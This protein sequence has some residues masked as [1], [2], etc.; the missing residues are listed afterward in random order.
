MKRKEIWYSVRN[1]GDGSAYPVFM[2][3]EK[4]TEIDQRY[5]DEGWGETCNGRIVLESETEIAVVGDLVTV[6][7]QI[8]ELEEELNQDYLQE[9][10]RQGKYPGWWKRLEDHIAAL[11]KLQEEIEIL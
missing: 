8:A 2:E 10:K 3:C 7:Q 5:L 9:Y 4:Q 6:E 1:G 11:K